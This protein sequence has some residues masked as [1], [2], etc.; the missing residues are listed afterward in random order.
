MLFIGKVFRYDPWRG[1]I[2]SEHIKLEKGSG[3]HVSPKDDSP[4]DDLETL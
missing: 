4:K 2:I 1:I 3:Y